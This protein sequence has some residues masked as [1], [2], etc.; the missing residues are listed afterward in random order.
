MDILSSLPQ[1]AAWFESGRIRLASYRARRLHAL[2]S[3]APVALCAGLSPSAF[4]RCPHALHAAC[5]AL[6]PS[7]AGDAGAER[8]PG[9]CVSFDAG[10][11][12]V[13]IAA[14]AELAA[15]DDDEGAVVWVVWAPPD[16]SDPEI[17]PLVE[18]VETRATRELPADVRG[19]IE[20]FA[21]K[22]KRA[23]DAQDSRGQTLLHAA[24]SVGNAELVRWFVTELSA[25]VD[26]ADNSRWTPLLTSVVWGHVHIAKSLIAEHQADVCQRSLNGST[27]LHLLASSSRGEHEDAEWRKDWEDVARMLIAGGVA[28]DA[29][30]HDGVTPLALCAQRGNAQGAA[31]LLSAGADPNHASASGDRP[32]H[33]AVQHASPEVVEALVSFG[34][35]RT[36]VGAAG[37]TVHQ[38]AVARGD[39]R[40]LEALSQN[41]SAI[42]NMS[43]WLVGYIMSFMCPKD[44]CEARLVCRSFSKIG[45]A[46]LRKPEY[47]ASMDGSKGR[48]LSAK[49]FEESYC[50]DVESWT[51]EVPET[52]QAS[53]HL[54]IMVMGDH[55]SSSSKKALIDCLGTGSV[56][57][58]VEQAGPDWPPR[59]GLFMVGRKRMMRGQV[60]GIEL[61]APGTETSSKAWRYTAAIA[62]VYNAANRES[63]NSLGNWRI[64]AKVPSLVS[65]W[66]SV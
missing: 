52:E 19:S 1:G 34:A 53:M 59:K 42:T 62:V 29:E 37:K 48:Y 41:I 32:L 55:L 25:S 46:L 23:I 10:A 17:A 33:V 39:E 21:R 22:R 5:W 51:Q 8:L 65:T 6:R 44:V 56:S 14:P 3:R 54:K 58:T 38:L 57:E 61:G 26:V 9:R 36:A 27:A 18:L 49:H 64:E 35:D 31:F 47:W 15:W 63:L 16:A 7:L 20:A 28:V 40:V 30:R 45:A 66:H 43:E 2:T 13:A 60:T 11:G 12:T 24:C 50:G 4:A